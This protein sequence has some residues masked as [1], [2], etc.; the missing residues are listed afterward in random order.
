MNYSKKSINCLMNP[1]EFSSKSL[2]SLRKP[3]ITFWKSMQPLL[4]FKKVDEG[5]PIS[6]RVDVGTHEI[7]KDTYE[8]RKGIYTILKELLI[9]KTHTGIYK[10]LNIYDIIKKLV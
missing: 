10:I 9:Y 4:S 1:M 3:M 8:I 7:L 5:S 6:W 2:N